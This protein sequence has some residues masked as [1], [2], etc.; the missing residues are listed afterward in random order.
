MSLVNDDSVPTFHCPNHRPQVLDLIWI[1]DDAF[2]WNGAQVVYDISEPASD[3][4]TL[5]LHI[6][7][8]SQVML[9]HAHLAHRYIPSGS[10]EEEHFV[11]FLFEA[12]KSWTASDPLLCAQQFIESCHSTWERFSKPSLPQFNRWWNENCRLAKFQFETA[13][14]A[15][16]RKAFLTQCK[17]AKKGLL[18]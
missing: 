5:T 15:M 7:D 10:E 6:G 12:Q 13:P 3:H 4:K 16:T 1:N 18:H 9:E 2:S 11:F 8:N 17:M 14:S